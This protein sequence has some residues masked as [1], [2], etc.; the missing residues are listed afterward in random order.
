MCQPGLQPESY[1]ECI[2]CSQ[3]CEKLQKGVLQLHTSGTG[4]LGWP[5]CKSLH[6]FEHM[7]MSLPDAAMCQAGGGGGARCSAPPSSSPPDSNNPQP[8]PEAV[9]K[10]VAM[11]ACLLP[12]SGSSLPV[13]VEKEE[14]PGPRHRPLCT[15]A[16]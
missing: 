7:A 4:T 11:G 14:Q 13:R 12:A 16:A 10:S 15:T 3:P 5:G 8:L 9:A 6:G 1:P 2:H